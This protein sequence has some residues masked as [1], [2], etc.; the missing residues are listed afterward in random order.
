MYNGGPALSETEPCERL[1]AD[2]CTRRHRLTTTDRQGG[3]PI[4][5]PASRSSPQTMNA[6]DEMDSLTDWRSDNWALLPSFK[7]ANCSLD[8]DLYPAT[9]T[10]VREVTFYVSLRKMLYSERYIRLS[11]AVIKL[12]YWYSL[13]SVRCNALH[14]TEYKIT[15]SVFLCVYI[16]ACLCVRTGVWGRKSQ[17]R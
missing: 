12:K 5:T 8:N 7:P 16:S 17:K 10:S 15:C 4:H 14:G 2:R 9:V 6:D 1:I 11:S 13:L 3:Y